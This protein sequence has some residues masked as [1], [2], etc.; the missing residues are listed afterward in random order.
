VKAKRAYGDLLML[1]GKIQL[2]WKKSSMAGG[3][4]GAYAS[5]PSSRHGTQLAESM[6]VDVK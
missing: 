1:S 2:Y 6:R 3:F 5:G 4:S